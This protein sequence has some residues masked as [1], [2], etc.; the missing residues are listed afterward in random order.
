MS[1]TI[2]GPEHDRYQSY[3]GVCREKPLELFNIGKDKAFDEDDAGFAFY[4]FNIIEIGIVDV[5]YEQ[6]L[7]SQMSTS[8]VAKVDGVTF[9]EIHWRKQDQKSRPTKNMIMPDGRHDMG[10]TAFINSKGDK[11]T[12]CWWK[13]YLDICV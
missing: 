9:T 7:S 12:L 6:T 10:G 2:S 11:H 4:F 3:L 13:C 5:E 8:D 1:V